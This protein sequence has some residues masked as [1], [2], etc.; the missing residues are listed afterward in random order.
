[1]NY[2]KELRKTNNVK[3][4]TLAELIGLKTLAAY[5]KKESGSVKFTVEEAIAI[6]EHIGKPVEEIFCLMS[7]LKGT[8][9]M[10]QR[11]NRKQVRKERL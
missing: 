10:S 5:Y 6:A 9:A 1:M 8:E 4:S 7:F 11:L 3:V 2:L